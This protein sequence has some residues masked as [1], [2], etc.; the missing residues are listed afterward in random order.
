MDEAVREMFERQAEWQCRRS[1]LSWA[2]K[3][4]QCVAMRESLRGFRKAESAIPDAAP[5]D[6][7]EET[8]TEAARRRHSTL[9]E[10]LVVIAIIAILAA[11][12]LPA[13]SSAQ[14]RARRTVCLGNLRQMAE[15]CHQQSGQRRRG[16]GAV[17]SQPA[18]TFR[19]GRPWDRRPYG[20]L[21]LP[22]PSR[23]S[24]VPE[25]AGGL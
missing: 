17:A 24:A 22:L 20:R 6:A 8:P 2:E 15:H 5:R 23:R 18:I 1:Q 16:P 9:I 21:L 13:L 11:L 25:A 4:R 14:E 3:L 12:L 10:L 7:E 19:P